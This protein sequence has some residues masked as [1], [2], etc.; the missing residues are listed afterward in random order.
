YDDPSIIDSLYLDAIEAGSTAGAPPTPRRYR[1][2]LQG[3][4]SVS[5]EQFADI[6]LELPRINY[7]RHNTKPYQYTY[8]AGQPSGEFAGDTSPTCLVKLDVESGETWLWAEENSY[9]GEPV[10]VAD[11]SGSSEDRGVLL[12][13]VLDAASES[14]Y[15]LVLDAETMQERVRARVP[16]HIPFGIHGQFYRDDKRVAS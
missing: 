11:P 6:A 12:S 2:A 3:T 10:F 7:E 15:L 9:P 4:P 13:V 14:S 8:G 1:I 5:M 16:H